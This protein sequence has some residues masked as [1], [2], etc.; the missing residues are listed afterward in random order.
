MF[1]ESKKWWPTKAVKPYTLT[2]LLYVSRPL[3][4][5]H[6][7]WPAVLFEFCC[8]SSLESRVSWLQT[9]HLRGPGVRVCITSK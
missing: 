9:S 6:V 4:E 8:Y 5:G 1:C 2:S 7:G 3:W